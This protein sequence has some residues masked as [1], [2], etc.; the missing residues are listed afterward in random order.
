MTSSYLTKLQ[1]NEKI[2]VK[3]H[4]IH[5]VT[6]NYYIDFK[7]STMTADQEYFK[8]LLIF[9]LLMN[10]LYFDKICIRDFFRALEDPASSAVHHYLTSITPFFFLNFPKKEKESHSVIAILYFCA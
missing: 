3:N 2:R 9:M 6:S 4:L 7:L 10:V 8:N 1:E 5:R